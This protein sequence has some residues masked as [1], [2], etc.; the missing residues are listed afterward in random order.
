[1]VTAKGKECRLYTWTGGALKHKIINESVNYDK[2]NSS[3]VMSVFSNQN[4]GSSFELEKGDNSTK[5]EVKGIE[6][7]VITVIKEYSNTEAVIGF[8]HNQK[9]STVVLYSLNTA[10]NLKTEKIDFPIDNVFKVGENWVA[11]CTSE[12]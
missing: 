7:G 4:K 10:T 9:T 11:I 6:D 2:Y 1:M 12:E 5:Y 8:V 3:G